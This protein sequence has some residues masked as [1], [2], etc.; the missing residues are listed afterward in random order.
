MKA[1]KSLLQVNERLQKDK[2]EI[3][4][5]NE[6][7][8]QKLQALE[9]ENDTFKRLLKAEDKANF[10]DEILSGDT[11]EALKTELASESGEISDIKKVEDVKPSNEMAEIS[12]SN[13][14]IEQLEMVSK[15]Y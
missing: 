15:E 2:K 9:K 12:Q 3:E 6:R 5:Q 8:R 7:L 14:D 1:N 11:I 13:A 10:V 4:Q